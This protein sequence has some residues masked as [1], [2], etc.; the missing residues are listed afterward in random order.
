[1]TKIKKE[2]NYW[3]HAIIGMILSV[4]VAGGFT[5][6]LAIKNPVEMDTYYMEKYQ[7]VDQNIN[8]ILALQAK[9][10]AKFDI[11]Y[12]TENFVL[13]KNSI[14]IKVLDK[15]GQAITDASVTLLLS[16]PE[17][18]QNNLEMQP[19]KAANGNYTFDDITIEKP[20]RWQILTKII[21]GEFQGYQKYEVYAAKQ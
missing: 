17:T 6:R 7:K 1:M 4:V 21:V 16:R 3:P 10:D 2:R 13:G 18:N 19:S 11:K 12:S 8:E 9:F 15:N 14:V 5:I 20:G